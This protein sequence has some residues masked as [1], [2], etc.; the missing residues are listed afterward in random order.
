MSI[1]R[2]GKRLSVKTSSML[3]ARR[4]WGVSCG[5]RSGS[6]TSGLGVSIVFSNAGRDLRGQSLGD[7]RGRGGDFHFNTVYIIEFK[8]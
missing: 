8:R 5:R 1:S 6:R 2:N 4:L 3:R 7:A